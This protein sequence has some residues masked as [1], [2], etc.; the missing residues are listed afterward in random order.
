MQITVFIV[1]CTKIERLFFKPLAI[2]FFITVVEFTEI[3]SQDLLFCIFA[4]FVDSSLGFSLSVSNLANISDFCK[5]SKRK[6]LPSLA[7]FSLS[8]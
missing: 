4:S 7:S 3:F 8:A 1:Y 2:S 6:R 5:N